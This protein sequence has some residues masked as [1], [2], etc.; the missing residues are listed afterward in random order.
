MAVVCIGE[1][2]HLH[3]FENMLLKAF[4]IDMLPSPLEQIRRGEYR[5][6][7]RLGES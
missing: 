6:G 7:A 5:L 1:Q 4:V 2:Q 3:V